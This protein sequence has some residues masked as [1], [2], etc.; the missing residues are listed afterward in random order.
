MYACISH[1]SHPLSMS[2]C[3][4]PI[5]GDSICPGWAP[6]SHVFEGVEN[7]LDKWFLIFCLK[8]PRKFVT[9][10]W[11]AIQAAAPSLLRFSSRITGDLQVKLLP[12]NG[13]CPIDYYFFE[14]VR[15]EVFTTATM[16]NAVLWDVAPYRYFVNRR[17]GG[18]YHFHLQGIRNPLAMNQRE[19][20][21]VY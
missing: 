10:S 13:A 7:F 5:Y 21:A 3:R 6:P 8:L 9:I 2:T 4:Q 1:L 11:I 14:W 17:S 15:F 16:K 12:V 20:V 19:Q 18:T